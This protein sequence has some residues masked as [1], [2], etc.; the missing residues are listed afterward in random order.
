MEEH[1]DRE[2]TIEASGMQAHVCTAVIEEMVA[3]TAQSE[4]DGVE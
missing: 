3:A 4:W 1:V 2:V